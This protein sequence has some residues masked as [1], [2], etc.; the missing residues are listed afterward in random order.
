MFVCWLASS[1]CA[2]STI[3][4]SDDELDSSAAPASGDLDGGILVLRMDGGNVASARGDGGADAGAADAGALASCIG[5]ACTVSGCPDDPTKKSPGICGCGHSDALDSDGDNTPDCIDDCP[6]AP[7]RLAD[8]TCGCAAAAADRDGDGTNNCSELCPSDP[9]RQ[10]PGACGCGVSDTDS[11]HDGTSDCLDLCPADPNKTVPG[12]CGCAV[13][14][15]DTDLDGVPDCIDACSGKSDA[16]YVSDSS[17]G[18]GYCKTHNKPSSCSAGVEK[19]CL[20]GNALGAHDNTCDGVDDDCD[21]MVDEDFGMAT[22]CGVGA[23][24]KTG[25]ASCLAGKVVDSCVAGAQLASKDTSCDGVDDD[26]D[27][28]T[29]EDYPVTTSSCAAGACASMGMVLCTEGKVVDSCSARA[30]VSSSDTTCNNVDDDCDTMVDEDFKSSTTH[31]GVGACATTGTTSC[32]HGGTVNSCRPAGQPST[33]DTTCNDVDDDCNGKVDDGYTTSTTHCGLGACQATGT[34]ACVGGSTQDSCVPLAPKASSDDAF[35]PGNGIDD[36]CDGM[37][38]EDVPA[39]DTT[40]RTF[41]AGSYDSIAVPGNCH[42]VAV[43]LWGGGGAGGGSAGLLKANGG[44]GGPGGYATATALINGSISLSVGQGAA[45]GCNAG[46]SNAASASYNGG[47]GGGGTGQAGA[48]GS[49]AGGGVGGAPNSGERGG[50]GHF[51]GGGG[52]AGN[53]GVID[54]GSAGGGGG[55]GA[56]SVLTI[57][58]ARA[59]VAGGGGGG[60]GA[61]SSLIGSRG[62]DGGSGCRGDG[63]VS[64]TNG[65]GG[66]G[67]GLCLG[68]T[69]QTGSGTNPASSGSIPGGRA[70][71]GSSSC[72]A[73]G[74]GYAILTF[75]P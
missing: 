21:G 7:D 44:A 51:G 20:A 50:D 6:L 72:N 8:G 43:S 18:V 28:N 27:G 73:G 19:Q 1:G 12:A 4:L 32:S 9:K 49:T 40:P 35:A 42:S 57:N 29:D 48:D 62:G 38:D 55:G 53:G 54:I 71:G 58:G 75:S 64:T 52:G 60:G 67:G 39:C 17:C 31:C 26:C 3:G 14:E 11:D 2:R 70:Q 74:A 10:I 68:A 63:Q 15:Q 37:V 47:S 36:D 23:C 69:T 33:T 13:S 66:G 24:A 25:T 5:P 30:P 34:L 65:G 59:A 41:E 46:G 56:A 45:S 22:S 16:R 61:Q